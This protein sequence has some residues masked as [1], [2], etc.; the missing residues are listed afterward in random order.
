MITSLP[1]VAALTGIAWAGGEVAGSAPA[2][3]G[4]GI[5]LQIVDAVVDSNRVLVALG[6]WQDEKTQHRLVLLDTAGKV[7]QDKPV[8][9]IGEFIPWKGGYGFPWFE[10]GKGLSVAQIRDG[11]VVGTETL[12]PVDPLGDSISDFW[13][14][15]VGGRRR[16][17]L[18]CRL[19]RGPGGRETVEPVGRQYSWVYQ[20]D[21]ADGKPSLLGRTCVEEDLI[22]SNDVMCAS[23]GKKVL[24][25]Q[26]VFE[27]DV[28]AQGMPDFTTL[29]VADWANKGRLAWRQRYMGNSPLR[30]FV[31][32][33]HGEVCLVKEWKNPE[34]ASGIL[35]CVRSGTT[36]V[37]PVPM[38]GQTGLHTIVRF[39]Y[40]AACKS[41]AVA[42]LDDQGIEIRLLDDNLRAAASHRVAI[43]GVT[44]F[45]L[46]GDSLKVYVV[47]LQRGSLLIRTLDGKALRPQASGEQQV[48]PVLEPG[49]T[50]SQELA[51][52]RSRE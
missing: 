3:P 10:Y 30:Y 21:L 27:I 50:K 28:A 24:I 31:D 35:C 1:L 15:T 23:N 45:A 20:Y 2:P 19:Y 17:L 42:Q 34:S 36:D 9:F 5:H 4:R 14:L 32:P 22:R 41:F 38:H 46:V 49:G 48:A 13:F 8:Q 37:N 7:L 52:S 43:K 51:V 40:L 12:I 44:D 26:V 6:R 39:R 29:R 33:S 16:L 47:C 18:M 25:W 11:A